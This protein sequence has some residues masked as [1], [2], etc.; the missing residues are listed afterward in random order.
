MCFESFTV[1]LEAFVAVFVEGASIVLV[2]IFSG[3]QC[4]FLPSVTK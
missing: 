1:L 2:G 3:E 4:P